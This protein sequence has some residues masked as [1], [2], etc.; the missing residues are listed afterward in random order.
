MRHAPWLWARIDRYQK[1]QTHTSPEWYYRRGCRRLFDLAIRLQ[2]QAIVATEVGC[3][4]IAALIKRDFEMACP[5][6]AVNGEYDSDRA[7]IQPEVDAYSVPSPVVRDELA[8]LGA[9]AWRIHDW[10]VPLA[11]EFHNGERR[12]D[13]RRAVCGRLGLSSDRPIVLVS[14]GSEGLGRPDLVARRLLDLPSELQVI[15]L[16]GRSERLRHRAEGLAAGEAAARLRVLG[17]TD[18]MATLMRAADVFVSK[19][20][21]TFDEAMA[22]GLPLVALE[23]PPGSE[24]AQYRL[25]EKWSAGHAVST[26][27]QMAVAVER[28]IDARSRG[29][30]SGAARP[31]PRVDSAAVS[32]ARWLVDAIGHRPAS[33]VPVRSRVHTGVPLIVAGERE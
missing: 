3:C 14:G 31:D 17:W 9:P 29:F 13:A 25:L 4:E 18:A 27:D 30:A 33:A 19:L 16:A 20:G 10:G 7:W 26:L 5:L 21:H 8:A 32:I 22:V 2:P 11:G 6:V 12:V 24:W 28:V 15:V 1:R 23:P